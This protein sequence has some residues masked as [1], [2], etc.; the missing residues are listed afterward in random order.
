MSNASFSESIT[1]DAALT[2]FEELGYTIGHGPHIAPGELA[3]KRDSF[4]GRLREAIRR[5]NQ[6]LPFRIVRLKGAS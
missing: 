6:A 2:W 1:K 4:G 3:A 5:L